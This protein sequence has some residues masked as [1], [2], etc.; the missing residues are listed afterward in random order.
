MVGPAEK[1]RTERRS[2]RPFFRTGFVSTGAW[3]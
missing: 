2:T 1:R 3:R